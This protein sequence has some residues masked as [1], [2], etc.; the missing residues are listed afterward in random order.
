MQR[1]YLYCLSL[2]TLLTACGPAANGVDVPNPSAPWHES[3]IFW[4][5]LGLLFIGVLLWLRQRSRSPDR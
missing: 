4:I 2:V 5:I 1:I 3:A